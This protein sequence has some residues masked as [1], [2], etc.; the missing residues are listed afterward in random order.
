MQ[1]LSPKIQAHVCE[2]HS[3]CSSKII[4]VFQGWEIPSQTVVYIESGHSNLFEKVKLELDRPPRNGTHASTT[5]LDIAML[6]HDMTHNL[7]A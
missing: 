1:K 6:L 7:P 5:P 2:H 3:K 4:E